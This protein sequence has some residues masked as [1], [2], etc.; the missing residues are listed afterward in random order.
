[1]NSV[2]TLLVQK[3]LGLFKDF[4]KDFNL[5]FGLGPDR[6]MSISVHKIICT[7]IIHPVWPTSVTIHF[8]TWLLRNTS[9]R[10]IWF[11]YR[12]WPLR[13]SLGIEIKPTISEFLPV[14]TDD[15]ALW[16]HVTFT[17]QIRNKLQI[18][19]IIR[20]L[21]S[22]RMHQVQ[23]RTC[24]MQTE[25]VMG[26]ADSHARRMMDV[27]CRWLLNRRGYMTHCFTPL[28]WTITV[29]VI[30]CPKSK[31][32]LI[33]VCV[34]CVGRVWRRRCQNQTAWMHCYAPIAFLS[35]IPFGAFLRSLF[36]MYWNGP[37]TV[38][39]SSTL[40]YRSTAGWIGM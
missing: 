20:C 21:G 17:V 5:F 37:K 33:V 32:P 27:N 8:G 10:S 22:D 31:K 24:S 4:F 1:M 40:L 25:S 35:Q 13:Y 15:Y 23:R 3:I 6:Y 12:T 30:M 7:E 18:T 11:R 9:F 19:R 14:P 28:P 26:L 36:I 2:R 16:R 34:D 39:K 38:P 29:S